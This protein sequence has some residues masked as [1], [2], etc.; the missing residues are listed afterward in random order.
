LLITFLEILEKHR[1]L[2]LQEWNFKFLLNEK[3]TS[4]LNQQRIYWKQRGT[5][6]CVK[7]D[8]GNTKLFHANATIKFRKN[9]IASLQGQ[10]GEQVMDYN[11]KANLLWETF[12]ER[13][14]IS[15]LSSIAFDLEQLLTVSD[16]LQLHE[17]PFTKNRNRSSD[18]GSPIRQVTR[19]RWF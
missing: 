11:S 13:L 10:N 17:T 18:Q 4:L 16:V 12:K 8:D 5:I 14:G 7:F 1:D 9:S 15:E 19:A 6:K 2:S 3:L